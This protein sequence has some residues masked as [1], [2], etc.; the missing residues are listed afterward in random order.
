MMKRSPSERLEIAEIE[1]RPRWRALQFAMVLGRQ[2]PQHW[3]ATE[4][5][6]ILAMTEHETMPWEIGG[7]DVFR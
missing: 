6:K 1:A 3:G 7:D 5:L 2:V 4:R